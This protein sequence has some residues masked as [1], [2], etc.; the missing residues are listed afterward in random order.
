MTLPVSVPSHPLV[1]GCYAL[2]VAL[3]LGILAIVGALRPTPTA[4]APSASP[5]FNPGPVLAGEI[6][7]APVFG[8]SAAH[9][10]QP[11]QLTC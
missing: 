2:P 3:A 10:V 4:S 8:E 11:L 1:R 7:D 9:L 5:Q 6:C